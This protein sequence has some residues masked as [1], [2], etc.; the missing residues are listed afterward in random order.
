MHGPSTSRWVPVPARC[1]DSSQPCS[2]DCKP[3]PWSTPPYA[4]P[5]L[6]LARY[7][8]AALS[9][10]RSAG[11]GQWAAAMLACSSAVTPLA[12]ASHT[13]GRSCRGGGMG[14]REVGRE[15]DM[16][17]FLIRHL[18]SRGST[19]AGGDTTGL[20]LLGTQLADRT[21]QV[22]RLTCIP[23][24]VWPAN[25]GRSHI[26]GTP[27]SPTA[28]CLRRQHFHGVQR[29]CGAGGQRVV[30]RQVAIRGAVKPA[31]AEHLGRTN[32]NSTMPL[33]SAAGLVHV[34]VALSLSHGSW[35]GMEQPNYTPAQGARCAGFG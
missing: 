31:A 25:P 9:R 17:V 3:Q 19:A 23:G 4:W 10:S 15:V 6:R 2:A 18:T 33:F 30:Q 11:S 28:T 16:C 26:T 34:H 20:R 7:S 1:P 32:P 14:G 22:W 21:R 12:A 8:A 13:S 35:Q 29:R 24:P 27:V 5:R